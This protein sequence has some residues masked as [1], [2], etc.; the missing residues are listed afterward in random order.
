MARR[1]NCRP[2][3]ECETHLE[4]GK[5]MVQ[6]LDIYIDGE[7]RQSDCTDLIPVVNPATQELL[8]NAPLTTTAEIDLAVASAYQAFLQWRTVPASERVRMMMS[9][10][11]L[12]KEKQDEIATILSQE[13]GKIFA[14][15]KGEVWR[16]IEVAEQACNIPSLMMGETAENVAREINTYSYLQPLGVCVGI[17]P[18]NFPAMIPLWM[19]PLAIACGNA[20]ILKPSEQDPMTPNKLVELFYQAG[21]PKDLIQLVHGGKDQVNHLLAHGRVKAIS[22][23]GSVQVG[24]HVYRRG[25]DNLKRV[26]CLTGAKNHLVIMP[27]ADKDQTISGLVGS[28]VGAAGQRCMAN[29]VAVFVGESREW[30]NDLRDALAVARPGPWDGES[31]AYGPQISRQAKERILGY[32]EKGK[33]EGATCLLDGS[34]C[35]VENYP[36]GNWVGPTLFSD[37]DVAMTIYTDEIFGPV[38][39]AVQVDS[40]QQA[41]ELINDS[42]YGNGTS[43]FTASGGA[44]RKFQHEVEAGQVGINVPIP[45]PLPFFS[46]TGWKNSFY[47]DQH[48]YGKQA[49]RFYTETKTITSRWFRTDS[50]TDSASEPNMT[51]KLR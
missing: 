3:G 31:A 24:Q 37:I 44:A 2:A 19:Y 4:K 48:A 18:F 30:I 33:E 46:F 6:V 11:M 42:P 47:G 5:T 16:G 49:V 39:L 51:I 34:E 1:A 10:Q 9:Y 14:D 43:I 36:L 21:F 26:Q 50:A 38:L 12:L 13:T 32:I 23:V 28:A 29:S 17:T 7:F 15:A 40:L 8:A 25:T 41:I 22:F 45:V 27:D 20:S 35:Q